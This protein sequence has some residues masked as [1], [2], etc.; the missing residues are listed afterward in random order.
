MLLPPGTCL[1]LEDQGEGWFPLAPSGGLRATVMYEIASSSKGEP[2]Y[3]TQLEPP[4]EVQ[5]PTSTTP[6]GL[7]AVTY[8]HAVLKSRWKGVALGTEQQVSAYLLLPQANK[9]L[10][11]T[12]NECLS[13]PIRAWT[14][15]T[16]I[17]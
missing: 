7:T 3:V 8:K 1:L 14:S 17:A 5:E 13:L 16:L 12:D 4:L 9:P 2:F 6:S 15:C 10:P 11:L